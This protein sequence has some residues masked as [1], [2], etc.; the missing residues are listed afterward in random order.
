MTKLL[1]E[2]LGYVVLFYIAVAFTVASDR[3]FY[4]A[5]MDRKKS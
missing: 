3:A 5:W 2:A 1:F 4:K